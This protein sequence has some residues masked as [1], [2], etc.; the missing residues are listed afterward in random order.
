MSSA[1]PYIKPG[2]FIDHYMEAM[3]ET[4]TPLIYDYICALWCL[5]TALGRQVTVARPA[6]SVHLNMYCILVS[7][8]GVMRKSSSIRFA[9]NL[10][11][12]YLTQQSS[13]TVLIES[14]VTMGMLLNELSKSTRDHDS[15]AIILVA[16]ELAAMLGRGTQ[17]AGMPAL[18]TDLYDCPDIR[19]GGGSLHTG[20]LD[21]KNVYCAFLAG[22]T[23]SWLADAV[24]PEIIAGGFTSRC[25]FI[26]G[27]NRKRLVAWGI[28]RERN[29]Q[30]ALI[31]KLANLVAESTNYRRIGI[32]A[33]ALR[34][35]TKWYEQ[36]PTH[37][38][39]YRESFES[40]EDSHVLRI[41]ALNAINE[42]A[43]E[44]NDDCIRRGIA[45]VAE[46]KRYGADLFSGAT[47]EKHEIKLLR[48]VRE[49]I[50][51]GGAGGCTRS[52]I[53]RSAG[54]SG[55]GA[56]TLRSILSTFHELDL[57]KRHEHTPARGRPSTVY[58]ATPY[59]QNELFLE[60]VAKRLGME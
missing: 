1:L 42:R 55:R 4:E 14:K 57:V 45:L 23:P 20:A 24:R 11:R 26:Q 35:Y 47:V 2:S 59:L 40:R 18:L 10:I 56:N 28:E 60:D 50:L 30:D 19:S 49:I 54:I 13:P 8:S 3:A 22:S 43:W 53:Y 25:Y 5:S 12:Q 39:V 37:K 29:R 7:E 36:R 44:I 27:R 32:N 34:T 41:A 16:S 6:A 48:K 15:A 21:F 31:E 33:E 9:T 51:A 38:D 46:I 58:T 17:I 52:T